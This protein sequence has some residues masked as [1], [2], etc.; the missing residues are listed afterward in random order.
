[1]SARE[2][3]VMNMRDVSD[4]IENEGFAYFFLDYAP[5][6]SLPIEIRSLALDFERAAMALKARLENFFEVD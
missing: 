2:V 3:N 6:E 4:G 1:M 5:N